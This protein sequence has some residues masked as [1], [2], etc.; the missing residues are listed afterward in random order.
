MKR[1]KWWKIF[2][3]IWFSLVAIFFTWNWTT[4]QS[5]NLPKGTF[6]NSDIVSVKETDDQII[7]KSDT[8]KNE[9]EPK[10]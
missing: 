5:H 2:K 3:I 10:K 7:F 6:L 1:K 4:F 9:M 8:T